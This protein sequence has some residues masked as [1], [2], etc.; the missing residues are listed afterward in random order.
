MHLGLDLNRPFVPHIKSWEPCNLTIVP[1][2]PQAKTPNIL[3]PQEK[4]AQVHMSERGQGLALTKNVSRGLLCHPALPA[5]GACMWGKSDTVTG[6][7]WP[8]G[9]V[10]V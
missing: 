10:E 8:R 2:G 6:L 1:D 9:W 7:V 4:G 3:P 5:Q